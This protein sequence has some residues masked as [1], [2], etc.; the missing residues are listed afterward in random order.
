MEPYLVI[1]SDCHAGL[2]NEQYRDWLDPKHHQALD[3]ELAARA[4]VFLAERPRRNMWVG[5]ATAY[6]ILAERLAPKLLDRYLGRTGVS[7]QQTDQDAPRLGSNV[8]EPRDETQDQGAHGAFDSRAYGR[9]PVLWASM[10]R[11]ALLSGVAGAA[12]LAGAAWSLV[13]R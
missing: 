2:P 5:I 10:H 3:E 1:S 9:D 13:R 4:V 12:A 8:F 11:A 6:T 7:S